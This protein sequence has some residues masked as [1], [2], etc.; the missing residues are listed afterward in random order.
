MA[1]SGAAIADVADKTK[2]DA[3]SRMLKTKTRK[4]CFALRLRKAELLSQLLSWVKIRRVEQASVKCFIV[5]PA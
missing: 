3:K 4:T 1:Q 2:A 5:H